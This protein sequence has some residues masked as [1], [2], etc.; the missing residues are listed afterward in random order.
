MRSWDLG[1]LKR[2]SAQIEIY[3]QS[4]DKWGHI[5]AD[6]FCQMLVKGR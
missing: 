5:V 6:H 1:G 3:D 4:K 2:A